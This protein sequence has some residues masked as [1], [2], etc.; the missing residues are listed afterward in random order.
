MRIAQ[1]SLALA[2][3]F[4]I[5][6]GGCAQVAASP[7]EKYRDLAFPPEEKNFDDGWRDR[8]ALEFEIVNTADRETLRAALKDE[9][10]F[11]RS[12]AARA[13]GI[14]GDKLSADALE[15]LVKSDPEYLVRIRAVESLGLLKEKPEAIKLA[16]KDPQ[17]GVKWAAKM[18]MGQLE[19]DQDYAGIVRKAYAVGIK[20]EAMGTAVIG[21]PA[22][23]FTAQ[24]IDGKTFK[25]SSVLGKKPIAIYFAAFDG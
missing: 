24:T 10:L 2:G 16:T 4:V 25:L 17:G 19:S 22:P 23:D 13:L 8:T 21:K 12:V 7:L 1:T 15:A 3:V 5:L 18:A 20:R 14:L 11:V 6:Q 9:D